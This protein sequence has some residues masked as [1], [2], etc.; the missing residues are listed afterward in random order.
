MR[1][2]PLF[3]PDQ[4]LERRILTAATRCSLA[5]TQ[6]EHTPAWKELVRLINQRSP[7]QVARMERERGLR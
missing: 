1:P 4:E 6:A 3:D 2:V 7:E 5:K